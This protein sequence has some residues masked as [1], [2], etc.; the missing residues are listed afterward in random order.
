M[1]IRAAAHGFRRHPA[2]RRAADASR[3]PADQRVDRSCAASY[4]RR[5]C[6]ATHGRHLDVRHHD[7]APETL[8][9]ITSES[10]IMT[11][12][13]AR[14]ACRAAHWEGARCWHDIVAR[15]PTAPPR[16]EANPGPRRWATRASGR[17]MRD[18]LL[19]FAGRASQW[20]VS[21]MICVRDS[22]TLPAAGAEERVARPALATDEYR[23]ETRRAPRDFR[24]GATAIGV[25]DDLANHGTMPRLGTL[26]NASRGSII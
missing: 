5:C 20:P 17:E 1:P 8:S 13:R 7:G 15:Y 21:A 18:R 2:R 4:R 16:I 10:A 23:E 24:E 19:G 11:I 25:G 3:E 22:A 6:A 26:Q 12:D 9:R 14:R